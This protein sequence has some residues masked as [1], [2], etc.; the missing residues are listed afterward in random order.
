MSIAI[1]LTTN[2]MRQQIDLKE[3][4][5]I[6]L[7]KKITK[8]DKSFNADKYLRSIDYD[9]IKECYPP[10]RGILKSELKHF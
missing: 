5:R 3:E 10:E 6:K 8:T 2:K 4:K 1:D 7:I 9:Y